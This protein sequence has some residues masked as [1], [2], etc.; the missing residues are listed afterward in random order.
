MRKFIIMLFLLGL[1]TLWAD[2]N[3]ADPVKAYLESPDIS[4]FQ[5][6]VAQLSTQLGNEDSDF[7]AR[8][9]LHHLCDLEARRM[10][11]GLIADADSLAP[12]E[13]FSL[14][15]YLLGK[16]DYQTA[17]QL[18][19]AINEDLPNWSCPWRHKGEA[20]YK[21][22]DYQRAMTALEQAIATNQNHYDAY[23]WMA[24]AQKELGL[25][26][27]ALANLD[28]ARKLNPGE[29][30]HEDEEIPAEDIDKLYKELQELLR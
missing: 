7:R 2:E 20:L 6:A 8:L 17:V 23:I 15:N 16:E 1:V 22:K 21:L 26:P 18:Y 3:A 11:D 25:Y 14:A 9:Y 10:L 30:G 12:G 19:D 24:R 29:E 5:A 13:R 27:D 4:G 28:R